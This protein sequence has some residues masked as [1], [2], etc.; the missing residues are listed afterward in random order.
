MTAH[1]HLNLFTLLA[2]LSNEEFKRFGKFLDSRYFTQSN[3]ARRFYAF[4]R[5]HHPCYAPEKLRLEVNFGE[6]FPERLMPA[7]PT[8]NP[9]DEA[10]LLQKMR[11]Q[12]LAHLLSDMYR[13]LETFL[14]VE[15]ALFEPSK[16]GQG[17]TQLPARQS[18]GISLKEELLVKALARRPAYD[19]YLK[20]SHALAQRT[21]ALPA[22]NSDD[23]WLLSQL[24]HWQYYH[25]STQK[26]NHQVPG[27]PEAMRQL[28]RC[29]LLSKLRYIAE[30][31]ALSEMSATHRATTILEE[32]VVQEAEKMLEAP[33]TGNAQPDEHS[34]ISVYLQLVRLYLDS[35]D[36]SKYQKAHEIF[37]M[38]ADSLPLPEVR[39]LFAHLSSIGARRYS[40]EGQPIGQ[41]LLSL[42]LRALEKGLHMANHQM[43]EAT[44]LNISALLAD[45]GHL[46][47]AKAFIEKR[48]NF[49]RADASEEAHRAALAIYCFAMG[50][51][52]Q[53]QGH[54]NQVIT[55]QPPYGLLSR[56]LLLK[57]YF[58]RLGTDEGQI[59]PLMDLALA[60]DRFIQNQDI[61]RT[62]REA[63]TNFVR[64]AKKVAT[65][66]AKNSGLDQSAKDRLLAELGS[67]RLL[68]SK[69]WLR[70]KIGEL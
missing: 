35:G 25:P 33:G 26:L 45:C 36:A 2:T 70:K 22:K 44:Y 15:E 53:A 59:N 3:G 13:L 57:I 64:F 18:G 30:L 54:I 52:D 55:N 29:Y 38:H 23:Y 1:L 51:F 24:H 10:G 48:K 17:D 6:L 11:Y 31:C 60:F 69:N 67:M 28:D 39:L 46:D 8:E 37:L 61:G 12:K 14:V 16:L 27:I 49:L 5:K 42:H 62:K 20:K 66:W 4:L 50:D 21:E 47:E 7:M 56:G 65:R 9:T 63:W 19:L 40:L 34:L 41:E 58:E 43:T 68:Y 32:A